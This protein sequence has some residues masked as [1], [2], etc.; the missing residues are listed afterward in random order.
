MKL[1][2]NTYNYLKWIVVVLL[3]ALGTLIGV[4]TISYNNTQN[5]DAQYTKE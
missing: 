1:G 4:S 5:S 2:N 3:P